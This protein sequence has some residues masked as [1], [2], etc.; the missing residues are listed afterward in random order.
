MKRLISFFLFLLCLLGCCA[1]ADS[2]YDKVLESDETA[3]DFLEGYW[4]N[5]KSDYIFASRGSGS[6]INWQT[7][8]P[9]T[10]DNIY[11]LENGIFRGKSLNEKSEIVATDI[12]RIE[13]LNDETIRVK[14]FISGDET[15]FKR[16]SFVVDTANL[17]DSYVFRTADRAVTYLQ[18][19]WMTDHVD[20]MDL[21]VD[22]NGALQFSTNLP[23]PSDIEMDFC[24]GKMCAVTRSETG[25]KDFS[26]IFDFSIIDRNTM[27]V[28]CFENGLFYRFSRTDTEV[29]PDN[30]D[31]GYV[32]FCDSRAYAFLEG[33]WKDDLSGH[34]FIL[35]NDSGNI[36]WKTD[37]PL[38]K[39]YSYSFA[40]GGL[41]GADPDE[42]GNRNLS[43]I[44]KFNIISRD[45]LEVTVV[46]DGLKYCLKREK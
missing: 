42:D 9:Y 34:Y 43:E 1:Y 13:I 25:K 11:V 28:K 30:I 15:E 2:D 44:Y 12:F 22:E 46:S 35:E 6:L 17:D 40:G 37:L 7:N 23:Y 29:D 5:G 41:F 20:F 38:E 4:T 45:L 36:S 31:T 8:L 18:G 14:S 33:E 19:E 24:D 39:H 27:M 10:S 3:I 16:D 21:T 26:P 32:F